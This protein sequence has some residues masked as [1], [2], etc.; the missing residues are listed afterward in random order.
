MHSCYVQ[1]IKTT[2]SP[3]ERN[4]TN[5]NTPTDL[6]L[7]GKSGRLPEGLGTDGRGGRGVGKVRVGLQ[8]DRGGCHGCRGFPG[9]AGVRRDGEVG[10]LCNRFFFFLKRNLLA[11]SLL[12]KDHAGV[13]RGTGWW[14]ILAT[15]VFPE[16]FWRF[17]F[18]GKTWKACDQTGR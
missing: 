12:R 9:H 10:S 15:V 8:E 7:T 2:A 13:R 11:V 5:Q 6:I 18:G 4:T 3:C 17:C 14:V 16:N 1:T